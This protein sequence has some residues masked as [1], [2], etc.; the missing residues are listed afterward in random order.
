MSAFDYMKSLLILSGRLIE[1]KPYVT[2]PH[3]NME[4]GTNQAD[5]GVGM[6]LKLM[7]SHSS[8]KIAFRVPHSL[9]G[10]L[11]HF[12]SPFLSCIWFKWSVA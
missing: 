5:A 12:P 3:G 2:Y 10:A 1:S 8:Y 9:Q 7:S 4:R 11:S 6:L